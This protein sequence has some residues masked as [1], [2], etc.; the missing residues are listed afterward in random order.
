MG[1]YPTAYFWPVR[2][3]DGFCSKRSAREQISPSS[4]WSRNQRPSE[5]EHCMMSCKNVCKTESYTERGSGVFFFFG[6]GGGTKVE[7]W[8]K[9]TLSNP[10]IG[11]KKKEVFHETKRNETKKSFQVIKKTE[12]QNWFV[13][14][15]SV[16]K[17]VHT[18][19]PFSKN[20][21]VWLI[22]EHPPES[23]QTIAL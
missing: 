12:V 2:I 1:W 11:F 7:E 19:I 20:T 3:R 17:M 23:L 4:G 18:P 13:R 10:C 16:W 5:R 14:K 21:M 6:M 9:P 15:E 8:A 22:C